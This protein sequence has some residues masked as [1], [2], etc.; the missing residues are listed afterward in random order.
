MNLKNDET[1]NTKFKSETNMINTPNYYSDSW[2]QIKTSN[3]NDIDEVLNNR[4]LNNIAKNYE[5]NSSSS[6][7]VPKGNLGIIKKIKTPLY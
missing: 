1:Q 3:E 5:T 6:P 7:T 2:N 4:Y